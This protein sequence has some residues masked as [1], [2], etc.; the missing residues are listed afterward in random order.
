[1][2]QEVYTVVVKDFETTSRILNK[3]F[4]PFSSNQYL[5]WFIN[6]TQPLF[7]YMLN[8][9]GVPTNVSYLNQSNQSLTAS[10]DYCLLKA[11]M[12]EMHKQGVE[13]VQLFHQMFEQQKKV[14]DDMRA[15]NEQIVGAFGT[16]TSM[17]GNGMQLSALENR[18]TSLEGR[19]A[20]LEIDAQV[21]QQQE[22]IANARQEFNN[23]RHSFTRS[24]THSLDSVPPINVNISDS[25]PSNQPSSH[26][27][28]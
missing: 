20:N 22:T 19:K 14:V 26:E 28:P 7:L 16:F 6:I 9:L 5:Q 8:T 15:Q 18:L 12:D 4:Q 24:L 2:D 13:T 1:M 11:E 10:A 27:D 25:L 3:P 23:F 21:R 17:L